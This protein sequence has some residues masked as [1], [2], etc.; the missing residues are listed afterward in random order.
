MEIERKF[1]L[2]K[3]PSELKITGQKEIEQY[4]L[5]REDKTVVRVRRIND[6]YLLTIKQ[7]GGISR[8]EREIA[9]SRNDFAEIA[10]ISQDRKIIKT[11]YLAPLD[12]LTVELDVFRENLE[13]LILAEIEFQTEEQAKKFIP[14]AWIGKEV[15]DDYRYTN[16]YLSITQKIPE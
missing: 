5:C 9:I 6:K 13:G 16:S 8:F 3:I 15:T 10:S 11:R 2:K 1:L 14:P 4:Y 7:G 12:N